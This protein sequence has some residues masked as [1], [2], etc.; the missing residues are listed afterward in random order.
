MLLRGDHSRF[1]G[2]PCRHGHDRVRHRHEGKR[3]GPR[4]HHISCELVR[5]EARRVDGRLQPAVRREEA[6][7]GQRLVRRH[8]EVPAVKTTEAL[9]GDQVAGHG[10]QGLGGL[11]GGSECLL[12]HAHDEDRAQQLRRQPA[13]HRPRHEVLR[14]RVLGLSLGRCRDGTA[15]AEVA[16]GRDTRLQRLVPR[17][18]PRHDGAHHQHRCRDAGEE[19]AHP[20]VPQRMQRGLPERLPAHSDGVERVR[21]CHTGREGEP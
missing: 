3:C 16:G 8:E 20:V 18:E 9:F 13:R 5:C 15:A 6:T 1:G 14:R 19:A 11:S 4:R 7:A 12:A 2:D 10:G 21:R 17:E